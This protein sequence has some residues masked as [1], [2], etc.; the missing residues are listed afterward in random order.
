MPQ[1][2]TAL[3]EFPGPYLGIEENA[4]RQSDRHQE[5]IVNVDLSQGIAEARRGTMDVAF[6]ATTYRTLGLAFVPPNLLLWVLLYPDGIG[7]DIV[8][9]RV[10][11]MDGATVFYENLSIKYGE[12]G[13][14][15][16]FTFV[17]MF[18]PTAKVLFGN[19]QGRTYVFDP[20]K[21]AEIAVY[22][23]TRE[24][25][26]TGWFYAQT[27]PNGRLR[28]EH[29]GAY[30][31]S[32]FASGTQIPLAGKIL[33]TKGLLRPGMLTAAED[34]LVVAENVV[35]YSETGLPDAFLPID[36][37]VIDHPEP[38]TAM[39]SFGDQLVVFTASSMWIHDGPL[40]DDPETGRSIRKVVDGI[41]CPSPRGLVQAENLLFFVSRD[42]VYAW[43]G[44]ALRKT[45]AALDRTWNRRTAVSVPA[46]L[47]SLARTLGW[48]WTIQVSALQHAIAIYYPASHQVWFAVTGSGHKEANRIVF[49]L[50][51]RVALE[52]NFQGGWSL[53]AGARTVNAWQLEA[54]AVSFGTQEPEIFWGTRRGAL[55]RYPSRSYALDANPEAHGT[56][57]AIGVLFVSPR[58]LLAPSRVQKTQALWV[59]QEAVGK[60][61]ALAANRVVWVAE[62]ESAPFELAETTD[63]AASMKTGTLDGSLD[64]AKPYFY[65]ALPDGGAAKYGANAA[66]GTTT[67][68]TRRA[69]F[70]QR[71]DF[72]LSIRR[73]TFVV[74]AFG[75]ASIKGSR[76][77]MER[78]ALETVIAE[79][80]FR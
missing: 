6:I 49:V 25:S 73:P 13:R 24:T 11:N 78:Y 70:D 26:N 52:T 68:Y 32:G 61:P 33:E 42:G 79:G 43:D 12:P 67:P 54:A 56:F 48:P 59:R 44:S 15:V 1:G 58:H 62:S 37:L 45:S 34:T 71:R 10:Q 2:N 41:G 57:S 19:G 8:A 23:A 60:T 4:A 35:L 14:D 46:P 31:V 17:T 28:V 64:D 9:L 76:F 74:V 80:Q 38:I 3:V 30:V 65:G 50:D 63:T 51:L 55:L 18:L 75:E 5:L 22:A 66:G 7:N 21:P 39:A 29:R 47:R 72:L 69:A 77:R 27:V 20:I 16:P 40:T 53:Y 36:M